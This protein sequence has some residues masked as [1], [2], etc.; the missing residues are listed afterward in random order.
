MTKQLLQHLPLRSA[1]HSHWRKAP[2]SLGAP[3]PLFVL[4]AAVVLY[5]F[6]H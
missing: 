2:E 6:V 5:L 4:L 1:L 3:W